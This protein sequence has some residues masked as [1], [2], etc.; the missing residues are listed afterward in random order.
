MVN[1]Q[2][3]CFGPRGTIIR[4]D[5]CSTS[6]GTCRI[7]L[8]IGSVALEYSLACV[9]SP[10]D[11]YP[12]FHTVS[13]QAHNVNM[14]LYGRGKRLLEYPDC[15]PGTATVKEASSDFAV[16]VDGTP[17]GVR[18]WIRWWAGTGRAAACVIDT[19]APRKAMGVRR[20]IA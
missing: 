8:D 12:I 1:V 9:A 7:S 3:R 10:R 5:P 15:E 14:R 13:V 4:R 2:I 18:A 11:S 17:G 20:C 16:A 19:R 6:T